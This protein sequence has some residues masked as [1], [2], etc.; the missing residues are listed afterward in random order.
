M[1]ATEKTMSFLSITKKEFTAARK[2]GIYSGACRKEAILPREKD[3]NWKAGRVGENRSWADW[4]KAWPGHEEER[5]QATTKQYFPC[6]PRMPSEMWQGYNR[7]MA[8][9][10]KALWGGKKTGKSGC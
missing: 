9:K 5:V 3:K 10:G 4:C 7:T 2:G 1:V 8:A 6:F